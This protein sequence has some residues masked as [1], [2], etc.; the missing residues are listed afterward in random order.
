MGIGSLAPALHVALHELLG[1]LLEDVVD[2]VEELVDVFLDL[3]ALLGDLGIGG[4][5][6]PT[7]LRPLVR[8]GFFSLLLCHGALQRDRRRGPAT[9]DD[10]A[11]S[12]LTDG[13]DP[14][15]SLRALCLPLEVL[16]ESERLLLIRVSD[17]HTVH[18]A[19]PAVQPLEP[20]LE[21]R[22]T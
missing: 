4:G 6:V 2:L 5:A 10:P 7:T 9:P 20:D 14:A 8:A 19:G 21:R 12:I 3:L 11:F 15:I 16:S 17:A 1:V 22:L 13:Q 18:A